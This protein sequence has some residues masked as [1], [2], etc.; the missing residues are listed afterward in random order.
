MTVAPTAPPTP[1]SIRNDEDERARLR[2]LRVAEL[3]AFLGLVAACVG[4]LGPAGETR[5]TYSWPPTSLPSGTPT[6]IW[7]TP[8]LLA[9]RLPEQL[10]MDVPCAVPTPLRSGEPTLVFS[11]TRSFRDQAG[12]SVTQ[13]RNGLTFWVGDKLLARAHARPGAGLRGNACVHKLAFADGRWSL[14]AGDTGQTVRG[15]VAQMPV[16]NGLFSAVDLRSRSHPSIAVTTQPHR[17]VTTRRQTVAWILAIACASGALAL[18]AVQR[19]RPRRR[20]L[21]AFA[22]SLRDDARPVDGVI[23][24][25]LL[26]WWLIAPS[27][28]DDG[29]T[30]ARQTSFRTSGGF[31]NYFESFAA[32]LP[33]GYWLE[34]VLHWLTADT[35]ALVVLRLPALAC[36]ATA[37]V[38][39]RW[40]LS[41]L[42]P[43]RT[44]SVA[45]LYAMA[46]AFAAMVFAWQMSF[47]YESEVAVLAIGT[48]ACCVRFRM[49]P[50]AGPLAIAAILVPLSL[51][52]HPAGTI[53][54]APLIALSPTLLRWAR[55]D[56][57][58]AVALFTAS[59]AI[60]LTLAFVGSDVQQRARD[61]QTIRESSGFVEDWRGELTR[62]AFLTQ[63]DP[64]GFTGYS[65]PLRRAAVAVMLLAVLA[66]IGR[67]RGRPSPKLDFPAT[68]LIIALALLIMTPTKWPWHFG[69]LAALGA[70]AVG[71]ESL[72][73]RDAA[74]KSRN[75]TLRPVA[76][77]GVT[78]LAIAWSWFPRGAWNL[79]D[80]RTID[81]TPAVESWLPLSKFAVALPVVILA[82]G[83]A[84]AARRGKSPYA[85]PWR[86]ASWSAAIL[87]VP[88]LVFTLSI[89]LADA[90]RTASW[91]LPRQ[92][93]DV[94]RG[95][96]TCGV[97]DELVIPRY[98]SM[99]PLQQIGS[100][101]T[102]TPA[103]V[104]PP[105]VRG[106]DRFALAPGVAPAVSPWFALSHV[107]QPGL[108]ISGSPGP[109]DRLAMEWGAVRQGRLKGIALDRISVTSYSEGGARMP[110]RLVVAGEVK[111]APSRATAVRVVLTSDETPSTALAIT[112][113]FS[114]E[115]ETLASRMATA[116]Q[117]ELVQPN[118]LPLMPCARLPKLADG[119]VEAPTTLVTTRDWP[120]PLPYLPS[121]PF[122]GLL[123]VFAF[124]RLPLADSKNPPTS[125]VAFAID[126]HI[127][128]GIE[129][130]PDAHN[131]TK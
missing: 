108:F 18:V 1:D 38:L 63:P 17:A 99:R 103:W 82:G 119:V 117:A 65:T 20:S 86:V 112:S 81:W 27:F 61:E 3:I 121:S 105:P 9:R 39:C 6:R 25:L 35:T 131:M 57:A 92:N 97:A 33:L 45:G 122:A 91:T 98:G 5:T 13:D 109:T 30:I 106:L 14:Q 4:A 69:A 56:V 31:S 58:A 49:T 100:R 115:S 85:V 44:T 104:P 88:L 78:S 116:P 53:A 111:S 60:L 23:A 37:W 29:W 40:V 24:V 51:S 42:T 79:L 80:L 101:T 16:V 11:T 34:W 113:P 64:D 54:L 74:A 114:Y 59:G 75:W 71:A 126:Q 76:A 55:S 95:A 47:R 7:Y 90:A 94:I 10:S 127:P 43:G 70:V 129:A 118:V 128:G 96:R 2:R 62:Y 93:I 89:L 123:D 124:E 32:N 28:F 107:R 77:I 87:V 21:R 102:A 125:L 67:D 83:L 15:E 84:V 26:G 120:T 41:E 22:A 50:G 8:L 46:I 73:L 36:I 110:W 68:A 52:I 19:R 12:L 48:A 130:P 66:F 72:R